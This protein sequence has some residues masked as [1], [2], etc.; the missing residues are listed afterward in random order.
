VPIFAVVVEDIWEMTSGDEDEPDLK[1]LS[2]DDCLEIGMDLE[3]PWDAME[4][5]ADRALSDVA[6][7]P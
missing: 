7:N 6:S 1:Q 5:L 3:T 2:V 4:A